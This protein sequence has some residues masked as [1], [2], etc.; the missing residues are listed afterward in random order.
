MPKRFNSSIADQTGEKMKKF[1]IILGILLAGCADCNCD[2]IKVD[3]FN[4]KPL[5]S[6]CGCSIEKVFV[7]DTAIDIAT[8]VTGTDAIHS[9]HKLKN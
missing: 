2:Y 7:I 9:I 4:S 6:G 5:P 3:P 1:L 8:E